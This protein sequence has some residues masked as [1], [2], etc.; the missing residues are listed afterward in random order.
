MQYFIIVSFLFLLTLF[1]LELVTFV[2]Y[3]RTLQ[4]KPSQYGQIWAPTKGFHLV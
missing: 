2:I 3:P 1:F 4:M